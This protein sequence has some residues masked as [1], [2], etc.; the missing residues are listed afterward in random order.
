MSIVLC[1]ASPDT[2]WIMSDGLVLDENGKK[3]SGN[4]QKF[5]MISPRL[6]VGYVGGREFAEL[7][8]SM[9]SKE[10]TSQ[11]LNDVESVSDC[12]SIIVRDLHGKYGQ[13]AQFLVAGVSSKGKTAICTIK[14]GILDQRLYPT[15]EYYRS[16]VLGNDCIE[17]MN[18]EAYTLKQAGKPASGATER[19]RRAMNTMLVDVSKIDKTVNRVPFFHEFK[20]T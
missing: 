4:Y 9:L 7:S 19:V 13:M 16:A 5:Q 15:E 12:L 6:C 8:C 20:C 1:V 18:L 11:C 14:N 2:V 3:V 17:K 10:C